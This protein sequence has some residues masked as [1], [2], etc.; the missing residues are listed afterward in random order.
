MSVFVP[1]IRLGLFAGLA[2]LAA[3]IGFRTPLDDAAVRSA[4]AKIK[5]CGNTITIDTS[6]T[7]PDI[8]IL[9]DRSQSMGGS[10]DSE[11]ECLSG[12]ANCSTRL[13][14]VNEAL[15]AVVSDNPEINWGLAL[16]PASSASTCTVSSTPQVPVSANSAS[17]I[18]SQLASVT[19]A[20]STPTTAIID[21]ATA[22]LKKVNDSRAK[23]ILLATDGTPTCGGQDRSNE[24]L[25]A[26]VGAA[27]AAK[28]AGFPVYVVGIGPNVSNLNSLAQAGGTSS[29]YPAT[30]TAALDT[31]LKSIA[32]AASLTCTFK[33]NVAPVDK[34]LATV[35]IDNNLVPK[36]ESDGW[37]YD[38]ADP[39]Y[40]TVVLTGTYCQ[41]MLAGGTSQVQIVF[42][43]PAVLPDAAP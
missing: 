22:Y 31:A 25:A 14:A 29:Y 3:C 38:P 6:P 23:S 42:A 4:D 9:L 20:S 24:D 18:R 36:D 19:T 39:E 8:L 33:A 10:L 41:K 12:S 13:A 15:N 27:T 1:L 35:Y 34:D 5:A 30:S 2:S 40:S 37:M 17:A 21:A 26:A 7:R 16:F 32:K 11:T 43:C 28:K